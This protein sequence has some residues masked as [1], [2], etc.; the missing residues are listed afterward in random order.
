MSDVDVEAK[1]RPRKAGAV[2]ASAVGAAI[3]P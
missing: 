2:A 1:A 3:L